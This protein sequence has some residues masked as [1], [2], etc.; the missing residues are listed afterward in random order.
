S[1]RAVSDSSARGARRSRISSPVV[2]AAPSMKI[3]ARLFMVF[4][5]KID[6][7]VR[8]FL[9]DFAPKGARP[10]SAPGAGPMSQHIGRRSHTPKARPGTGVADGSASTGRPLPP[11][12][13]RALFRHA[14]PGEPLGVLVFRAVLRG[15]GN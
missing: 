6:M 13:D 1:A 8:W 7:Q 12:R 14:W 4:R 5:P 11:H 15:V 2:P 10:G 3:F 9:A